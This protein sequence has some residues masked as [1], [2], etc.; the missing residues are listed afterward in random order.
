MDINQANTA[1][2]SHEKFVNTGQ[3]GAIK[4]S[5]LEHFKYSGGSGGI[6]DAGMMV[7]TGIRK[8]NVISGIRRAMVI[9]GTIIKVGE[10]RDPESGR[11]VNLYALNPNPQPLLNISYKSKCTQI[12]HLVTEA[13][14]GRIGNLEALIKI[15][16][17][18]N[19]EPAH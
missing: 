15:K 18:L 3:K 2:K 6:S 16:N 9:D 4:T 5:V 19:E 14:F 10:R 11:L 8:R 17:I 13:D 7:L 12:Q 1:I